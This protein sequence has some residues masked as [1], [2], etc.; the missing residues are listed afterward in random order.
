VP[1]VR[2]RSAPSWQQS[3]L[4]GNGGGAHTTAIE[5]SNTERSDRGDD[6]DQQYTPVS[7]LSVELM[8]IEH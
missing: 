8:K 1:G 6:E 4:P 3:D 2:Q 5:S 7:V